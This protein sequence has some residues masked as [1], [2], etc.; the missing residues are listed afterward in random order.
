[1]RTVVPVAI[2]PVTTNW[3][4]VMRLDLAGDLERLAL[5]AHRRHVDLAAELERDLAADARLDHLL[6]AGRIADRAGAGVL[7]ALLHRLLDHAHHVLRAARGGVVAVVGHHDR[8]AVRATWRARPGPTAARDGTGSLRASP[9]PYRG[10]C[11]AG[12]RPRPCA[13]RRRSPRT[14]R[15]AGCRPAGSR[16]T[17]RRSAPGR[18][19]PPGWPCPSGSSSARATG[20]WTSELLMIGPVAPH[21]PGLDLAGQ[22]AHQRAAG[23]ARGVGHVDMRVGAVAGDDR[24]RP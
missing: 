13:C 23:A 5:Q 9:R 20:V 7:E 10:S 19:P 24:W 8:A 1:M 17:P 4:S 15:G 14:A 2:G 11:S 3:P 6:D 12:P 21:H 18:C 16:R 22:H